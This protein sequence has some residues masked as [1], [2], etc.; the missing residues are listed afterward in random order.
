M[1]FARRLLCFGVEPLNAMENTRHLLLVGPDRFAPRRTAPLRRR[2]DRRGNLVGQLDVAAKVVS[3]R[4]LHIVVP[5]S[6]A[7]C[8]RR[9]KNTGGPYFV[10]TVAFMGVLQDRFGAAPRSRRGRA[11]LVVLCL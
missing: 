6:R 1:E 4:L 7:Y 3:I 9:A 8:L 10:H 2:A 11:T 5:G